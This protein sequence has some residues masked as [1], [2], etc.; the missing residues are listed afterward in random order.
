ML[1]F[2]YYKD[3]FAIIQK[4]AKAK[5]ATEKKQ[6][7]E[8]RRKHLNKGELKE[9]KEIVKDMIQKEE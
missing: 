6:M 5:F 1:S 7:M 4:H 9:Y 8:T 3:V 2:M